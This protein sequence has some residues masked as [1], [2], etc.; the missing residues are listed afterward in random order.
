M[1]KIAE[2][3]AGTNNN[4]GHA[5]EAE[6]PP[7]KASI[8]AYM[9]GETEVTQE[10]WQAV[11]G[12]NPSHFQGNE[13]E[14]KTAN[15]E[16]QAKRPVKDVSWYKAIAF[17]NKLTEKVYGNTEE[18]V[19]YYDSS[20]TTVYTNGKSVYM[21]MIY[22]NM[23]KKGFRLPTE[24][25]WEWAAKGG[26][27]DKYAGTNEKAKLAKY[28]WYKD[29]SEAKTHEVARKQPNAYGLYDM[30][31]NVWEWCSDWFEPI[32][33]ETDLGKD[34]IGLRP[35][36]ADTHRVFRGGSW[37]NDAKYDYCARAFRGS[38]NLDNHDTTLGFRLAFAVHNP[39]KVLLPCNT[40]IMS[41]TDA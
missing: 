23:N 30:S 7:H 31:G 40:L 27:E 12:N 13:A 16:T 8:S 14:K 26:T 15:G 11:M 10:L 19:Y 18:C 29:N 4:L 1:N 9:I 6:N 24:A 41:F 28:T 32:T 35:H 39:I 2:V 38:I 17:C 37:F 5:D 34:H 22:M 36:P 25:E 33:G 21:N 20:F 3:T